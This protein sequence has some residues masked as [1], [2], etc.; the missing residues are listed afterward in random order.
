MSD[1]NQ[2]V[3]KAQQPKTIIQDGTYTIPQI[4][5]MIKEGKSLPIPFGDFNALAKWVLQLSTFKEGY[6]L[7][8]DCGLGVPQASYEKFINPDTNLH[9]RIRCVYDIARYSI[10]PHMLIGFK[11]NQPLPKELQD[12]RPIF[13][14]RWF[15]QSMS[16]IQHS[17]M[18][19]NT[20]WHDQTEM[21]Y[22]EYI[23]MKEKPRVKDLTLEV[24]DTRSL[25]IKCEGKRSNITDFDKL[26]VFWDKKSN[27]LNT[28]GHMLLD[29]SNS[30]EV[31]LKAN[32]PVH[33]TFGKG[34]K[35]D[36]SSKHISQLANALDSIVETKDQELGGKATDRWF[37]VQEGTDKR[38][39]PRFKFIPSRTKEERRLAQNV[40]KKKMTTVDL[41]EQMTGTYYQGK[42]MIDKDESGRILDSKTLYEESNDYR[43]SEVYDSSEIL[44]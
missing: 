35:D 36:Q 23:K 29:L 24:I 26:S 16:Q 10:I 33:T 37:R 31:C 2:A 19:G 8:L 41:A 7:I 44:D 14:S 11:G 25:L 15:I 30:Y 22:A 40:M 9:Q 20:Y 18:L 6:K 3:E 43:D 12:W 28:K 13:G 34:A 5:E 27:V 1:K 32:N 42:K 17:D 4:I 38:W 21:L 39:F